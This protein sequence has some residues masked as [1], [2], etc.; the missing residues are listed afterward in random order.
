MPRTEVTGSQIK[1]ASVSLTADVTGVLPVANGG[2]G[3]GSLSSGSVLLGN[4]SSAIQVVG[5]G[6][7]GNV[8]TSN[9]ATWVSAAPA[10]GGGGAPA[11]TSTATANGIT[12]LTSSSTP[13]QVFTGTSNQSVRLPGTSITQGQE[14]IIINASSGTVGV[15][16]SGDF[17]ITTLAS[18]N[19]TGIFV[20]AISAPSLPAHWIAR[21]FVPGSPVTFPTSSDTLAGISATQTLTNKRIT[22]RINTVA[23]SAT[24]A[25]NTDTTDQFTITALAVA[26]TSMTTGLTG[27]PTN[28]QQLM[29]R[30]KDNGTARTITWGASFLS[31]GAASLLSTTVANKTHMMGLI[32]DTAA[33]KWVCVASDTAGY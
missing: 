12:T 33:A 15:R 7:T 22:P 23:S 5:P 4:G 29:I 30:I 11:V 25:I 14:F 6:T 21:V 17:V 24:P 26:I 31:S 1:D 16:S 3:S 9:G 10:A 8:L 18:G 20:S 27:T 19:T 2:I 28:G 32:Y 13:V